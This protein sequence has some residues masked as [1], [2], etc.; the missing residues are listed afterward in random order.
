MTAMDVA[1]TSWLLV[2]IGL[3]LLALT[4]PF[5]FRHRRK[6]VR[7]PRADLGIVSPSVTFDLTRVSTRMDGHH[8]EAAHRSPGHPHYKTARVAIVGRQISRFGFF[9]H[10]PGLGAD[11]PEARSVETTDSEIQFRLG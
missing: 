7:T 11:A 6:P 10:K 2:A 8:V 5:W 1:S 4:L 9:Q 3:G